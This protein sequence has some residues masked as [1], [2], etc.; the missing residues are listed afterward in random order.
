M[1]TGRD[2]GAALLT[3]VEDEVETGAGGGEEEEVEAGELG[4][5]TSH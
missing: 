3:D 5:K 2:G 4:S 1:R